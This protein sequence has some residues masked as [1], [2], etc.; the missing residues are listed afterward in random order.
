[1]TLQRSFRYQRYLHF[2]NENLEVQRISYLQKANQL[3]YL[4]VILEPLPLMPVVHELE[5]EQLFVFST[6]FCSYYLRSNWYSLGRKKKILSNF[7]A[8][9]SV[10]RK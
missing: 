5:V 7:N 4:K 3:V 6:G 10:L 1:M 2:T 8:L 9:K